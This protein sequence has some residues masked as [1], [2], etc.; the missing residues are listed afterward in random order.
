VGGKKKMVGKRPSKKKMVGKRPS[1]KKTWP[2]LQP[3]LLALFS[4]GLGAILA[5]WVPELLEPD[6][7]TRTQ[8][9]IFTPETGNE[10][11][12]VEP[13]TVVAGSCFDF[14]YRN[15]LAP[16]THTCFD[17]K[18]TRYD[19]C[20]ETRSG[21]GA[22]LCFPHPWQEEPRRGISVQRRI[23]RP[24]PQQLPL[25]NP[26]ALELENG[27]RC[28]YTPFSDQEVPPGP[29][30]ST[31]FCASELKNLN[32]DSAEGW[33]Y[34][35]IRNTTERTW[36]VDYRSRFAPSTVSVAVLVEWH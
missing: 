17:S 36:T 3:W 5:V 22:L 26:W 24:N 27:V 2:S 15:P 11:M 31:Y 34:G 28:L 1:K 7:P 14:S 21:I 4:V 30:G 33:V 35:G 20:Y 13:L 10:L 8:H 29:V 12:Q 18:R 19:P 25:P 32:P 16:G 23:K 6:P 9:L